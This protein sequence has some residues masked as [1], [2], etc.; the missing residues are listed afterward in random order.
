VKRVALALALAACTQQLDAPHS[1][2]AAVPSAPVS[3][4]PSATA[5]PSAIPVD[6]TVDAPGPSLEQDVEARIKG[7]HGRFGNAARV[8]P[9][10]GLFVLV[11]VP[12]NG[13]LFVR[14][15]DLLERALPALYDGKL[16]RRPDRAVTVLLFSTAPAYR[17][18]AG[19][20]TA[21]AGL[22]Y[23]MFLPGPREIAVDLS[24]GPE[25]FKTLTHE[26]VHVLMDADFPEA[27][28]WFRE[29]LA[30]YFEE[31]V[32]GADGSIRGAPKNW[33]HATLLAALG[34]PGDRE[35]VRLDRAFG[36]TGKALREGS[37]RVRAI[38][39]ALVRSV[40]AWME[41][42]G[43]L[44]EFYRAYREGWRDDASGMKAF[45]A[46]MGGTPKEMEGEW[47]RWVR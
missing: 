22:P 47:L 14:A 25:S 29:G 10:G 16:A 18:Y 5:T 42:R 30:S 9:V 23:G 11:D 26:A 4:A 12:G 15:K 2:P 44:W 1:V 45:A 19:A 35:L 3:A 20:V 13:A 36:L 21:E 6:A 8:A 43:R 40:C 41:S 39:Y 27:R 38:D 17:E 28:D 33:R 46:V 7:A 34:T 24:L 32:F 31:P 37:E